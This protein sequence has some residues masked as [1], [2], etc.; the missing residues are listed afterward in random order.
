MILIRILAL[1][2]KELQILLADPQ[3]RQLVIA[4]VIVQ[5]LLFPLAATLEVKNN[6]LAVLNEDDK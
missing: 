3:S 2:R 1:I 6:T 5:A 4:P